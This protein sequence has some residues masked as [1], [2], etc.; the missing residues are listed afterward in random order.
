MVRIP[1]ASV[2]E[3]A[4][5]R[6]AMRAHDFPLR[7][8][9]AARDAAR[10]ALGRM[11]IGAASLELCLFGWICLGALWRPAF[12][13]RRHRSSRSSKLAFSSAYHLTTE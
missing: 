1:F 13:V 9:I 8:L 11:H 10:M 3:H 7:L 2:A 6:D 4:V 12:A 5:P